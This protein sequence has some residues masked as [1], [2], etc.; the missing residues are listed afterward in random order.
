MVNNVYRRSFSYTMHMIQNACNLRYKDAYTSSYICHAKC[1]KCT[2]ESYTYATM[3]LQHTQLKISNKHQDPPTNEWKFLCL[4]V[5]WK[6][7]LASHVCVHGSKRFSFS[8][9]CLSGNHTSI[10]CAL[11]WNGALGSLQE[12]WHWC[13]HIEVGHGYAPYQSYSWCMW[14][15]GAESNN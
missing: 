5:C 14:Y 1:K 11:F 8:P 6:C 9:H 7:R 15:K 3:E 4:G 13:S 12:L 2:K 10:L